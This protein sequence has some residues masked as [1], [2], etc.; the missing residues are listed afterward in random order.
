MYTCVVKN[1]YIILKELF[2]FFFATLNGMQMFQ[3]QGSNQS[4]CSDNIR[5]LPCCFTRDSYKGFSDD[6]SGADMEQHHSNAR[7]SRVGLLHLRVL[8]EGPYGRSSEGEGSLS[9]WGG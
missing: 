9:K 1:N 5:S 7:E 3:G 8:E 4:H 6:Q 2:F